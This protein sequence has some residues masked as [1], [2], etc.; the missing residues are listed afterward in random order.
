[1]KRIATTEAEAIATLERWEDFRAAEP[2]LWEALMSGI[3]R[4]LDSLGNGE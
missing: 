3:A 4:G 2:V 1:M